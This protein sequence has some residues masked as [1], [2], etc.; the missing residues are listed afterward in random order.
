[1]VC[2]GNIC[3]SPMAASVLRARVAEHGLAELVTVTSSGTSGWHVGDPADPRA[4]A[5]LAAHGYDPSHSAR[6]LTSYDLDENDLVLV[7]DRSNLAN[8]LALLDDQGDTSRVRLMRSF[9][10]DAPTD[11]EVP[12]P[13]YGGDRGFEDVLAMLEAACDG[14][15]GELMAALGGRR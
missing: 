12:D 7:A 4:A 3:R 13:Y 1:M 2:L 8:T 6:R 9:D 5:T 15:V 11:A 14:L 10:P